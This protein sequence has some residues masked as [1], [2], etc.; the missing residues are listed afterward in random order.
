M[1]FKIEQLLRELEEGQQRELHRLGRRLLPFLTDE[2]LLQPVDYP[3]LENDPHFRYEEGV[4]AGIRTVKAA[5]SALMM[6]NKIQTAS[7]TSQ[8][9]S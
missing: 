3:E 1:F 6:E 4:L 5:V 9:H 8:D 7:L 2:D